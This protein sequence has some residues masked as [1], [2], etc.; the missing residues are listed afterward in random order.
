MNRTATPG[1]HLAVGLASFARTLP[2]SAHRTPPPADLRGGRPESGGSGRAD[3]YASVPFL[4]GGDAERPGLLGYIKGLRFIRIEAFD[5]DAAVSATELLRFGHSWPAVHAIHAARWRLL[6]RVDGLYTGARV[7]QAATDRPVLA[8]GRD[9]GSAKTRCCPRPEQHRRLRVGAL[10]CADAPGRRPGVLRS[11][12]IPFHRAAV[13]DPTFRPWAHRH[14][15]GPHRS[16]RGRQAR[17]PGREEVRPG[18]LG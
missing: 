18:R 7:R 11:T 13:E 3:L 10:P 8:V 5:T 12:A 1:S 17:A 15:V 14:V 16:G 9:L 6:T 2:A 4:T